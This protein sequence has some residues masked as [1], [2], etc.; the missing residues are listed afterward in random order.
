MNKEEESKI[1]SVQE[2]LHLQSDKHEK[3]EKVMPDVDTSRYVINKKPKTEAVRSF[4]T[5]AN[6]TEEQRRQF[7]QGNSS[8]KSRNAVLAEQARNA[9]KIAEK[10]AE[11]EAVE[12]AKAVGEKSSEAEKSIN[13]L[14]KEIR[15]GSFEFSFGAL[16]EGS[17]NLKETIK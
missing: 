4:V 14:A 15:T 17:E 10:H 6:I 16:I 1:L 11:E 9:I 7:S 13:K 3:E 5:T 2:V 8:E 12:R